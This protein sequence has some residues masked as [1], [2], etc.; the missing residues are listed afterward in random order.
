MRYLLATVNKRSREIL[1]QPIIKNGSRL[2]IVDSADKFNNIIHKQGKALEVLILDLSMP[3]NDL[4]R[5]IFYI[6]QLKREVPVILLTVDYTFNK[7]SEA[8]RNLSVYGCIRKPSNQKEL[9][10]FLDDLNTIFELDMDKKIE[11]VNYLEKEDVFVCTFKNRE[12]LFLSRQN[13]PED[14]GSSI[15]EVSIDKNRYYF[16]V[17]LE[18]GKNYEVPWDFIRYI[19]DSKYEFS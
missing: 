13:I 15:K 12:D 4:N 16:R 17:L 19:C 10:K 7:E 11:K 2:N 8:I 5:F 3:E 14:D 6:R 18:S 9:F 1:A